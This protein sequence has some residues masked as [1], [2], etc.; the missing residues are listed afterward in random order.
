MQQQQAQMQYLAAQ[1]A[2]LQ[3]RAAESMADAQEGTKPERRNLWLRL[4][5]WKIRLKRT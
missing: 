3:A 1:T 2:E 4:L 5:L